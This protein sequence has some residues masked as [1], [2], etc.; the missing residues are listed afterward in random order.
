MKFVC[1]TTVLS[2]AC[3]NVQ[4]AVSTKTSIPA[5][6]G[7]LI[8]ALGNEIIL[9]GYDLELGINTSISAK[10]EEGGSII[11]NA[12]VLCDILRRLPDENVSFECDE[13][14]VAI[15]KSGEARFEIMGMP[16]NEYPE[17]PSVTGG[18]PVVLEQGVLKDMVRQT[19]FAVAVND[20]KI[21][22][23]GIKFEISEKLIKLIA[24]DGFRLAIRNEV[25]DYSGED[26]SFVVPAKTLSEVIKLLDDDS[27]VV[28]LGVGKR[29]IVFE[30][31]N[32]NIISRLLDGE[33]L[34]Y[35]TAIPIT[36]Q[37]NL[38]VNVRGFIESIERT[39]LIITDKIKSP[40]RCEIDN[41]SIRSSSITSLGTAKDKINCEVEGEP[42]IIG[43]NNKFLTDALKVCDTD[44][45]KMK[46]NGP[47]SPILILPP[48]GDKFLYLVLPVRL[49]NEN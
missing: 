6:E 29:H 20:S 36:T 9:T 40:I 11:I 31:G 47:I 13:R 33:F 16:A 25:I 38:K 43:F 17:L 22:H 41:N 35:K 15:I 48:S 18:F 19:I 45:I 4:R 14:Y 42:V 28:A 23:T 37:T 34:N 7:I 8:K 26:L 5:V 2:E 46:L 30:I 21:V 1:N 27:G 39:S 32:Y 10:T 12:R 44:E 3:Q 49:K 24:V